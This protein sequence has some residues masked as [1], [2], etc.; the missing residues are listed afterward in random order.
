MAA[1]ASRFSSF[2]HEL[3]RRQVFRVAIAYAAVAW[4]LTQF[5]ATVFPVLGLPGWTVTLVVVLLALGFPVA[6]LLAWAYD[7]TPSGVERTPENRST[8]DRVTSSA[9]ATRRSDGTRSIAALPFV[10]LSRE[11]TDDYFSDGLTEELINAL[12]RVPGLHVAARTSAFAFKGS[13]LNVREIGE[14]LDVQ[15]VLEGSVR[16]AGTRLRMSVQLIDVGAGFGLWAETYEREMGDVFRIQEEIARAVVAR[17]LNDTGAAGDVDHLSAPSTENLEAFQLYLK[18]RYFWN[19][20][21]EPD[22]H[23]AIDHFRRAIEADPDYALAYAGLADSYAILLDYG[24]VSPRDALPNATR[25]AERALRLGPNLAEAHTSLALARQ[26][27]WRWAEAEAAFRDALALNP[28]YAIGH[29]RYA[30]FLSWLGRGAEALQQIEHAR[31]LDP[32]NLIIQSS[33]GWVLYY[34]RRFQ[35][36]AAQLHATLELDPRFTNAHVALAMVHGRR[37]RADEAVAALLHAHDE[38]GGT[39]PIVALLGHAYGLANRQEEAREATRRLDALSAERY[40]SAYYRALPHLG[41]GEMDAALEWL[42]HAHDER[43]ANLVYLA[44]D[45]IWDPVRTDPRFQRILQ[46]I[47][48]PSASTAPAQGSQRFV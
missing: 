30:L 15:Y 4:L 35:D 2:V 25:A 16:T 11:A 27:E 23:R 48:F 20:R 28:G 7:I 46:Q 31:K 29:H 9:T 47:D 22:L 38:T 34:A 39:A 45:A 14:R 42:E 1:L 17:V 3:R 10:N 24:L 43:A 26:F 18:G 41:L 8:G 37:G 40:V 12:T 5:A 21:S 6:V 19:R 32:V 36:A 13:P 33:I 44:A